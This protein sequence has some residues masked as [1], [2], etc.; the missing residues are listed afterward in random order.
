VTVRLK[1]SDATKVLVSPNT[2]TAG[3]EMVDLFVAAGRIYS[4]PFFVQGVET[5]APV[6]SSVG[7]TATAPGYMDVTGVMTVVQPALQITSLPSQT[8]TLTPNIP[9]TIQV[10]APQSGNA[11]LSGYQSVRAGGALKTVTLT[12]SDATV[13]Q[14]VTT[15]TTGQS[16]TVDIAVGQSGPPNTVTTGGVAFDPLAAGATTVEATIPGFITTTGGSKTV[17]VSPP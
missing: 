13:G 8:T 6:P 7:I 11:S 16:V 10:G 15:A 2:T 14:L 9:F 3:T 5:A 1:S 12:S 17:T 4:P